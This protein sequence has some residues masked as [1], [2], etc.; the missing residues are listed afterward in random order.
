MS[1]VYGASKFPSTPEDAPFKAQPQHVWSSLFGVGFYAVHSPS[2]AT[3]AR[4]LLKCSFF[5]ES[6]TAHFR[7]HWVLELCKTPRSK[8]LP[9]ADAHWAWHFHSTEAR[10]GCQPIK[11]YR[12]DKKN[13]LWVVHAIYCCVTFSFAK[14]II[15]LDLKLFQC[16]NVS[17][18]FF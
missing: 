11:K 13:M 8:Q 1:W 2:L 7:R 16:L 12:R 5:A 3:S 9:A 10:A 4:K 14:C 6:W 17:A 18:Y 15:S